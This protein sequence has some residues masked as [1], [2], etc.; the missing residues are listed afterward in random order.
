MNRRFSPKT[1]AL[2]V[3]AQVAF[4]AGYSQLTLAQ[5]GADQLEEVV[6]TGTRREARSVFD[7]AAP[8]DVIGLGLTAGKDH[9]VPSSGKHG[10]GGEG[11]L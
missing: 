5:E 4:T 7:S 8:I 9:Q 1:L 11:P 10:V 3:S 6:V 2:A